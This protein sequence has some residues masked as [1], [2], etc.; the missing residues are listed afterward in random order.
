MGG[1]IFRSFY[2]ILWIF[3]AGKKKI[4]LSAKSLTKNNQAN[5]ENK[6][7]HRALKPMLFQNH[8][9]R[10]TSPILKIKSPLTFAPIITVGPLFGILFL[11]IPFLSVNF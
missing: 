11:Y 6:I 7:G 5:G 10:K 3:L 8:V 9:L 1:C 2:I 4:S